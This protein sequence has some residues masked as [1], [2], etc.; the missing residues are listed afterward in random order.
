MT[1]IDPTQT[2]P[3]EDPQ[4]PTGITIPGK[5]E[6]PDSPAPP[7]GDGNSNGRTFTAEEI[8]KARREEKDKLYP[9]ISGLK[10]ELKALR[11]EREKANK[12]FEEAAKKEADEQA[13]READLK[14]KQEEEM[15]AKDLLE[16][17]RLEWEN[18]F[19][20]LEEENARKDA[21]LVQERRYTE[22]MSY[23]ARR[24]DEEQDSIAPQLRDLV[25]LGPDEAGIES[26]I[27]IMQQKTQAILDQL[28]AAGQAARVGQRGTAVSAPPVGPLEAQ[29]EFQTLSAADLANLTPEQYAK[30]RDRLLG[31]VSQQV[32]NRGPY[33][34]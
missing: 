17:Q 12:A 30:N 14:K 2:N 4:P 23:R 24:L 29:P 15:S 10:E 27:Q 28:A 18:R 5:L 22:L 9:E 21:I 11:A 25:A 20:T 33:G 1:V 13:R 34:S 31:A 32:R 16:Q 3:A 7:A 8:E 19:R 6:P 26:S